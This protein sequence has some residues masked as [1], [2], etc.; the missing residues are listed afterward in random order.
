MAAEYYYGE[1]EGKPRSR[2]AFM[3]LVDAAMLIISI[4]ALCAML[5]TLVT[6]YFDP[7]ISWIF[8]ITGLI[9]PAIFVGT[10]LLALYWIIRW[11]WVYATTLILPLLIAFPNIS[12]YAKIDVSK[13]YE[14]PSTRGTVKL[15]S[16]N[17]RT[18]VNDE[19]QVATDE[20]AEFLEEHR[21]DIICIQEYNASRFKES[22]R[23]SFMSDYNHSTVKDLAIFTR[24]K[25]LESS[26]NLVNPS[27]DSGSA[28]WSDILI[29]ED[30]LRL[31]NVHLHSTAITIS[32]DAYIRNMEFISDTLSENKIKEML[33]RFKNTSVGRA[34]QADTIANSISHT[35]HRVA[36]CG[37][38][39]D[40][41]NSYAFRKIS[42]GLQDS[43]QEV[44]VG[45]SYTFRGFLNLLRIDYVLVDPP[46]EIISYQVVDTMTM[47]DH[48]PVITT[49]KL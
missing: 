42:K 5:L 33:S 21:P 17:T 6:S 2:S 25:I 1:A 32:D 45:Y 4:I 26:E 8:P 27:F 29:G 14:T 15:M 41:P 19:G 38:F 48:L 10:T 39:N 22:A 44:G 36:V 12:Y 34:A 18:I 13:H 11:R 3:V 46:T 35:P 40:T 43:F 23:P 49:I 7:S 28:Y 20:L 37:D 16:Y 24:Y 9:S 47:S 31:Y 30:T